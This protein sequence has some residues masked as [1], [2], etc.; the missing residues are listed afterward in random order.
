MLPMQ[1]P[2]RSI[3]TACSVFLVGVCEDSFPSTTS[4]PLWVTSPAVL[5]SQLRGDARD[6]PHL[7]GHTKEDI[8]HYRAA[9]KAHDQTEERRLAYVA[10]TRAA[11]S[12]SVSSYVWGQRATPFGPSI[13]QRELADFLGGAEQWL[14]RPPRNTPNPLLAEQQR[15]D[16]PIDVRTE[17]TLA[18]LEAAVKAW[19]QETIA[20]V[21]AGPKQGGKAKAKNPGQ[22]KGKAKAKAKAAQ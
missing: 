18:R 3:L 12:L 2:L 7:Q 11:Q 4:R 5:P 19:D 15:F 13:Y 17:E 16:W 21:F 9:G 22:G 20:P 10:L 6:L 1:R 8:D 14:D